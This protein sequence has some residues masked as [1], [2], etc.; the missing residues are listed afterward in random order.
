MNLF[1]AYTTKWV[2]P[3]GI[4]LDLYSNKWCDPTTD[5][6]YVLPKEPSLGSRTSKII[7]DNNVI[8]SSFSYLF[9]L[10]M[11]LNMKNVLH[12]IL[13]LRVQIYSV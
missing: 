5:A 9:K 4:K 2:D 8:Y 11:A 12:I 1:K 13:V 7:N 10:Q 3:D 6:G